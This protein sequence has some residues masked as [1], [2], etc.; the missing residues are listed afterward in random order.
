MFGYVTLDPS[1]DEAAV[2]GH[3][4]ALFS[5]VRVATVAPL[6]LQPTPPAYPTPQQPTPP[7]APPLPTLTPEEEEAEVVRLATSAFSG[8][9]AWARYA[10]ANRLSSALNA[11]PQVV[12]AAGCF[13]LVKEHEQSLDRAAASTARVQAAAEAL[14]RKKTV[15]RSPG[16]ATAAVSGAATADA[17]AATARKERAGVSAGAAR[18]P[19]RYDWIVRTRFDAFWC[20][21]LRLTLLVWNYF[22]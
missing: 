7:R 21:Y 18:V 10:W 2:L 3:F 6:P 12:R 22:R 8:D 19:W 1:V 16:A 9:V 5:P 4:Y 20:A 13:Q 14:R 15:R 11:A 17:A